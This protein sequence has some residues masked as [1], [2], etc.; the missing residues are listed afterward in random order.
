MTNF[1]LCIFTVLSITDHLHVWYH[2]VLR[3]SLSFSPKSHLKALNTTTVSAAF[4]CARPAVMQLSKKICT[5]LR[6]DWLYDLTT[7]E[8]HR[9]LH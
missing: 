9:S 8:S 4:L 1:T 5:T 2:E 3:L 7:H 6:D